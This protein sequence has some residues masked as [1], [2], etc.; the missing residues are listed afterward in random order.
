MCPA[1]ARQL[2]SMRKGEMPVV[3]SAVLDSL[4]P[5]ERNPGA[6]RAVFFQAFVRLWRR[7]SPR[8]REVIE[9]LYVKDLSEPEVGRRLRISQPMVFKH[10]RRA[11][12]KITVEGVIGNRE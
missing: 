9:L 1:I 10:H 11:L 8:Q 7:L 6:A 5:A 4:P 12:R 2:S 3:D